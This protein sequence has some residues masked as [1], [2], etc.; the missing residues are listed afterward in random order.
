MDRQLTI[1]LSEGVIAML[2]GIKVVEHKVP[3]LLIGLRILCMLKNTA[4]GLACIQTGCYLLWDALLSIW[5]W[6]CISQVGLLR[7]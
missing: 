3:L 4:V 5:T 7:V 6:L 1:I 2:P